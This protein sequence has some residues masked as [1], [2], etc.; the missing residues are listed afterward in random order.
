MSRRSIGFVCVLL[1]GAIASA[2]GPAEQELLPAGQRRTVPTYSLV[3]RPYQPWK[4]DWDSY[5][6]RDFY[7]LISDE[8]LPERP[9]GDPPTGATFH[10]HG[11]GGAAVAAGEWVRMRFFGD[12]K[13][14]F[15]TSPVYS[16]VGDWRPWRYL[17]MDVKFS[18]DVHVWWAL[19]DKHVQPPVT[20]NF[21]VKAG[22]WATLQIDLAEAAKKRK[23]DLSEMWLM[24]VR[25]DAPVG[26]VVERGPI[27]LSRADAPAKHPILTDPNVCRLPAIPR[28]PA[29]VPD[30][31]RDATPLAE[32]RTIVFPSRTRIGMRGIYS[33]QYGFA[34]AYDAR[35]IL[36]VL[37][38]GSRDYV[39]R[40]TGKPVARRGEA[41]R[42]EGFAVQTLDGGKTW[43]GLDG[44]KN[45]S[46][47][48][49]NV[50]HQFEVFD[51]NAN[52]VV[53][54]ENGCGN[55]PGPRQRLTRFT[56]LGKRGW[57]FNR[58][59]YVLNEEPRHCSHGGPWFDATRLPG[60]R[61]WS[62]LYTE[63][64]LR[65]NGATLHAKFSDSD[66]ASW[67]TWKEGAIARIPGA[68]VKSEGS[69][70]QIVPFGDHVAVTWTAAKVGSFWTHYN[71]RNGPS[72]SAWPGSSSGRWRPVRKRSSRTP[73]PGA[74]R[75]ARRSRPDRSG[76][77]ATS[78]FPRSSQAGR[79]RTARRR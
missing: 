15:P 58:K 32:A 20:G 61:I 77:T 66:G 22:A 64:R 50:G 43:T 11:T 27:R 37:T 29:P 70:P 28:K 67:H 2:D 26:C 45:R 46:W 6:Y 35:R 44:D 12:A 7:S 68:D 49:V 23:L 65:P 30:V 42:W 25:I 74:G 79:A 1:A 9:K 34:A 59:D 62:V 54:N 5:I 10:A 31:K 33:Q 4:I 73:G 69:N 48:Y 75:T 16:P 38:D 13:T 40:K 3:R 76:W 8:Q 51:R 19:E 18:K 21:D 47:L 60:G 24:W 56:F 39:S 57:T 14:P 78:G 41:D 71:A 36:L 52:A 17:R 55:N 53:T 72:R 63:S